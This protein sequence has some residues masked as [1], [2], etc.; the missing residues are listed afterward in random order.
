MRVCT[1]FV[2]VCAYGCT[3]CSGVIRVFK[4]ASI[5]STELCAPSTLFRLP[6]CSCTVLCFRFALRAPDAL[7]LV[8]VPVALPVPLIGTAFLSHASVLARMRCTAFRQLPFRALSQ[9]A[10]AAVRSNVCPSPK[11]RK[12][13]MVAV[14]LM[15]LKWR[16][17]LIVHWGGG[18]VEGRGRAR[19][20]AASMMM[21]PRASCALVP[22]GVLAPRPSCASRFFGCPCNRASNLRRTS[23]CMFMCAISSSS[24]SCNSSACAT[25]SAMHLLALALGGR[26]NAAFA[27]RKLSDTWSRRT[28]SSRACP[29]LVFANR[30]GW[31]AGGRAAG[32]T[33]ATGAGNTRAAWSSTKTTLP[34]LRASAPPARGI[35]NVQTSCRSVCVSGKVMS[36]DPTHLY[37]SAACLGGTPQTGCT[38]RAA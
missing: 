26:Y 10:P 17:K 37:F 29:R 27:L 13:A 5:I 25:A 35:L 1:G 6:R 3:S 15:G 23:R 30:A 2:P 24:A 38:G 22:G 33:A 7:L 21:V 4:R 34:I 9:V 31:T 12:E 20:S 14:K 8:P 18:W 32:W 16:L 28:L 11:R 36:S 19:P